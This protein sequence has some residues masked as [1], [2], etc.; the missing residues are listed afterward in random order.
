MNNYEF[1]THWILD[2]KQGNDVR[3]LDYGCGAGE[4]TEELQKNGIDAFGCDV[5]YEAG[6][7]ETSVRS[8]LMGGVIKRMENSRIPFEANYFDFVTNNQ[9]MEHVEDLNAV[10]SEIHRVLKPGGRVLSL[11]PD[12]AVWREGHCGIPFLHWFPKGSRPPSLLCCDSETF[13]SRIL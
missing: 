6:D 11:F 8:D 10:L 12:R 5:F 9:V 13:G 1:C 3:V 7:Y 2:Q 4:I